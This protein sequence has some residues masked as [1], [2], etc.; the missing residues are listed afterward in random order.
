MSALESNAYVWK[1]TFQKLLNEQSNN[2]KKAEKEL[3]PTLAKFS[4]SKFDSDSWI[5]DKR[6]NKSHPDIIAF[7]QFAKMGTNGKHL[8]KLFTIA[9]LNRGSGKNLSKNL[10]SYFKFLNENKLNLHQINKS[11]FAKY[12]YWLDQQ[13]NDQNKPISDAYKHK[14]LD[15]ALQFHILMNGHSF[16]A[17]IDGVEAI[18]NPYD[19]NTK[20]SKYKVIDDDV[21]E[22]LD[23]HFDTEESPLHIRVAY[24]I[25]RMFATRPE[26]TLNYPLDCVKKLTDNMATIK[27]AIV[28]NSANRGEIEYKIGFLNLQEPM[29]KMLFELIGKQQ[30]AS[31]KLQWLTTKKSFL[32]TYNSFDA[33]N[34]ICVLSRQVLS[35]Y[36]NNIQKH[37]NIPDLIIAV[38][39]DFKKTGI[40]MRME[41][42]WTSPQLKQ[43]SNH[44][45]FSSIDAYSAPSESFMITEQ[46][47]LLE[48]NGDIKGRF[49]FNGKIVNGIGDK[50]EANLLENPRAHKIANLGYCPDIAGCGNH[51]ECLDCSDLI[52]DADLEGYY[53]DQVDRYLKIAEKQYE[54]ED[55]TNARDSH[56]RAALF[57]SLYNK[58]QSRKEL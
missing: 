46:K 36:F 57:A 5:L 24:W 56:H 53:L 41:S 31:K 21:L 7:H 58:I 9:G 25:M 19:R 48:A 45:T 55:K 54:M 17:H 8:V 14:L 30:D 20:N 13:L 10:S 12:T 1:V 22:K 52:P 40:T 18:E 4:S 32:F 35:R 2:E 39:R 33:T 26:D 42:G 50:Y 43:F 11:L 3:I 16:M 27:H 34:K 37:M 6:S 49:V 23:K 29:Q 15:S 28:K 44:R 47:K 38:P 51:L